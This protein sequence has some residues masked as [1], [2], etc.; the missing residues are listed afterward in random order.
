MKAQDIV[1]LLKLARQP[2]GWTFEKIAEELEMSPSAVHRSLERARQ[3]GLYD[4]AK[5]RVNGALLFE[6]LVHGAKYV[7]P[8]VRRGEA[9]G[10][11]TAGAAA[12]LADRL[13]GSSANPPV[14]PDA[15]GKVRGIALEPLHPVVPKVARRDPKLGELL[16]LFDTIRIGDARERGLAAK[17]LKWRLGGKPGPA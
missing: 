16:A 17:E 7:F 5:K 10:L 6:F 4:A 1:V 12:P 3:A 11:P 8:A 9:R 14:W 13:S 15:Q 2:P